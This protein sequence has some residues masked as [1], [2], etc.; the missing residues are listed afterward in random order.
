MRVRDCDFLAGNMVFWETKNSEPR[1][2][3]MTPSVRELLQMACSGKRPD[4]PVFT[5]NDGRGVKDFRATWADVCVSTGLGQFICRKCKAPWKD[6]RCSECDAHT[7]HDRTYKGL[8]VHDLR[9]TGIRNM[10]RRGV[11]EQIAM[12]I[13]GH[14]T[15][16]VF[17]RYNIISDADLRNAAK[18][19]EDGRSKLPI[20]VQPEEAAAKTK[21]N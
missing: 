14:K 10:I 1:T 4:D 11:T 2:V 5:W 16:S 13:S 19:I 8:L 18:Q 3:P 15:V 12:K 7:R 21:P 17:R 20:T 9:R 6:E